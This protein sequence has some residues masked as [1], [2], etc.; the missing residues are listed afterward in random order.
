MTPLVMSSLCED[1]QFAFVFT[2][3]PVFGLFS[4]NLAARELEM[5]FGDD[6]NDLPLRDFQHYMNKSLLMLSR[7]ETDLVPRLSKNAAQDFEGLSKSI[8][9]ERCSYFF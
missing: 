9:L 1:V 6:A 4:L 2:F 3:V 5:P 8:S 7:D